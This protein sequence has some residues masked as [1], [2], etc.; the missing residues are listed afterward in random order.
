MVRRDGAEQEGR[1]AVETWSRIIVNEVTLGSGSAEM[2]M[3]NDHR[4]SRWFKLYERRINR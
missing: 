3:G 4:F 1:A 2:S